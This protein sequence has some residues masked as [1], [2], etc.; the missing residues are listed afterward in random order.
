MN[1]MNIELKQGV[2]LGLLHYFFYLFITV[3]RVISW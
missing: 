1:I 3:G 2:H